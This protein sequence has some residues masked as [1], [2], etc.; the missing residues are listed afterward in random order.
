MARPTTFLLSNFYSR[1]GMCQNT[2]G[3]ALGSP[4]EVEDLSSSRS[5]GKHFT[6]QEW[7][8]RKDKTGPMENILIA[9]MKIRKGLRKTSDKK[10]SFP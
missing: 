9:Q 2:A 8:I 10:E 6:V 5:F 7:I 3:E 1:E 4:H